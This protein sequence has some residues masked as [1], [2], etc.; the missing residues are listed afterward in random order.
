M[1]LSSNGSIGA[2][3]GRDPTSELVEDSYTVIKGFN[4]SSVSNDMD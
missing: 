1:H 4:F 3:L 2:S